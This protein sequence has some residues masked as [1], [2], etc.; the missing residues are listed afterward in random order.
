MFRSGLVSKN[1]HT[2]RGQDAIFLVLIKSREQ[3]ECVLGTRT[4]IGD[5]V[6]GDEIAQGVRKACARGAHAT[7]LDSCLT[8]HRL[9]RF[10]IILCDLD[11]NRLRK[12]NLVIHFALKS[13]QRNNARKTETSRV[14]KISVYPNYAY[15]HHPTVELCLQQLVNVWSVLIAGIHIVFSPSC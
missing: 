9:T 2:S 7:T 15:K 10:S 5:V 1:H 14:D 4:T 3:M 11:L 13:L 12:V 6:S 8:H